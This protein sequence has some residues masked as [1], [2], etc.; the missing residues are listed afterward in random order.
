MHSRCNRAIQQFQIV[1]YSSFTQ[2]NLVLLCQ[3]CDGQTN[4]DVAISLDQASARPNSFISKVKYFIF[5]KM[6][7]K[8]WI[9]A[10]MST[11][12]YES[13]AGK[14]ELLTSNLPSTPGKF[15]STKQNLYFISKHD[16]LNLLCYYLQLIISYIAELKLPIYNA[17]WFN[18]YLAC[19]KSLERQ[20][21]KEMLTLIETNFG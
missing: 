9:S 17:T 21:I 18:G 16:Q 15:Y 13:D 6:K 10:H 3:V 12:H 5:D 8:I 11:I 14:P 1:L 7:F 20:S 4:T 19:K 2:L